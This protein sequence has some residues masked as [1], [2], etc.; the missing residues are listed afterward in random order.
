MSLSNIFFTDDERLRYKRQFLLP[1]IGVEG[2][3]KLKAAKV[4]VVGAGGLGAPV[5][6]YLAAA[7]LGTIGI[8]D[9]DTVEASNLHRQILFNE[10]DIGRSKVKTATERLR[11]NNPHIDIIEHEVRLDT[12]NALDLLGSYD[13]ITDGTDNFPTRFLV[14]DACVLLGKPLIHGSL[15]QFEGQVSV[16]NY[17]Q[18]NGVRGPNYRDLF[19][20]LPPP[21]QSPNCAE[22]G[23][24]GMLP[25][26]IGCMQ[27]IEVIKIVTGIGE[28]LSGQLF[29][30]DA[31][32]CNTRKIIIGKNKQ[33][34]ITGENPRITR[35]K[36]SNYTYNKNCEQRPEKGTTV[37]EISVRVLKS[38]LDNSEVAQLIDVREPYEADLSDMGGKLIPLGSIVSESENISRSGKVVIH[39]ETGKRS[40]E[41]IKKLQG[42]FGFDN[43]YNLKGGIAAWNKYHSDHKD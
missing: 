19:L 42:N 8:I 43:L 28:P 29:I 13:I 41:A 33:N 17:E 18:E 39:C 32:R 27:A 15:F 4:L 10:S 26:M 2:Q 1:Q 5:M 38:W 34:P 9:F 16:F 40:A 11:K 36:D 23:I 14:N 31:L 21:D 7:G 6:Q 22:T 35:L 25:G 12:G 24:L 37:K 30:F 3:K 20:E